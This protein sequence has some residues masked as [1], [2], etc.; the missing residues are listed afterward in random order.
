RGLKVKEVEEAVGTAKFDLSL[1][2]AEGGQ[3]IAGS[4]EYSLD[5]Y[6]G[7]TIRRMARQYEKVL[8]VVVRD[9]EQRIKGIE[10]L[11]RSERE[12]I[13]VKW[14]ETATDYRR[15]LSI[16]ELFEEQAER[17]PEA[18]AVVCQ[19]Q[20]LTYRELNA[21]ANQMARALVERGVG[22]EVL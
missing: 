14:N 22:P 11:D 19:D 20:G 16:N 1:T 9:G 12:Q 4:F 3:G 18:M 10:L 17:T 6:E 2:L 5:L 8:G 13:L 15:N 7:E 21:L